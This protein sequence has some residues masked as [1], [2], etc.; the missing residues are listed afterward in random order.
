[1]LKFIRQINSRL[2]VNIFKSQWGNADV[3]SRPYFR[4]TVSFTIIGSIGSS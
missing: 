2:T 4:V 1:M 3:L